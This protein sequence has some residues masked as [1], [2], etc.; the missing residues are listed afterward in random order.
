MC[1][2]DDERAL[3]NDRPAS[4]ISDLQATAVQHTCN[5]DGKTG[6]DHYRDSSWGFPALSK[7]V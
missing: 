7:A 4:P 1:F 5:G 6:D 3:R 2:A